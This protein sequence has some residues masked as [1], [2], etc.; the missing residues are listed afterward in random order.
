M[1]KTSLKDD[2]LKKNKPGKLPGGY[3]S[4]SLDPKKPKSWKK[5]DKL[6][7]PSPGKCVSGNG[8]RARE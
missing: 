5:N 7:P 2:Q 6:T 1:V 8:N 3:C 4:S